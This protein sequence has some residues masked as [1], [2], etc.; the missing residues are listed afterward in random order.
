MRKDRAREQNTLLHISPLL[1]R[2]DTLTTPMDPKPPHTTEPMAR[3]TPNPNPQTGPTAKRSGGRATALSR[4]RPPTLTPKTPRPSRRTAR[5]TITT[6]HNLLKRLHRAQTAQDPAQARP[7]Q[8]EMDRHGGVPAYQAASRAGQA[9]QR[10]GDASKVLVEWVRGAGLPGREGRRRSKARML[11]VGA[12]SASNACSTCG[13]FEVER[14]DLR[15][16]AG[17]K[18]QDFMARP[19]PGSDV[20]R[21]DV[22]SLSLVLNYVGDAAG[23]GEML[24]RAREFL[25][26]SGRGGEDLFPAVFVA[27]PAAC[28]LNSRYLH[29]ERLKGLMAGL[30][31]VVRR[32]KVA[33]R[34]GYWLFGFVGGGK[35]E[36]WGK[37]EVNPGRGRNNFAVVVRGGGG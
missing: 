26:R 21:F 12:L 6:H 16:G 5:A 35:G 3:P 4:G 20:E 32:R 33:R 34:V 25:V 37:V 24:A 28:V 22:V 30:G 19:L 8:A 2:K 9:S 17:V 13:L 36:G 1:P 11:E 29:E 15:G 10:G 14:I 27:L 7:I 31:F 23:R 18:R